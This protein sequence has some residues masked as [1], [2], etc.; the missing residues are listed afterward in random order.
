M[1]YA[2]QASQDGEKSGDGGGSSASV[3]GKLH[4]AT[5]SGLQIGWKTS[6]R[7]GRHSDEIREEGRGRS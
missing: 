1:T 2:Y 4:E 6:A 3:K 5:W 7:E